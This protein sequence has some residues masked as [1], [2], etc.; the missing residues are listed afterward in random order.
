MESL[1]AYII[2]GVVSLAVGLLLRELAPKV[3]LVF[4]IPHSFTFQIAIPGD[5]STTVAL[6]THAVT[7]QNIG[8]R[9]AE[10]LEIVLRRKPDVFNL[11]PALDFTVSDTPDGQQVIRLR[12]LGPKEFF[13]IEFLSWV[14]HPEVLAIR[15]KAGAARPIDVRAVQPWRRSLVLGSCALLLTGAGFWVYWLAKVV[16]FIL[17]GIRVI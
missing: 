3:R 11:A 7:I 2:T 1:A 8:R 6:L 16:V 13:T 14:S 5:P 17:R 15:S 9:T 4:W 12:S 10:E